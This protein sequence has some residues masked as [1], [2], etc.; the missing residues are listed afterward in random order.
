MPFTRITLGEHYSDEQTAAISEILHQ[1]LTDEFAVPLKDKFQVFERLPPVQRI[2]DANYQSGSRSKNFI[3]FQIIAGKART[4][5]QK[6]NFY[7]VLSEGLHRDLSV[8]PDD[9]MVIIQ[10]NHA[11]DWS[12]SNGLMYC[13]M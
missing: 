6:Q 3:L 1:S 7:R 5:E 10:F 11:S 2:F 9:V 4:D 12:F 13:P 8:D